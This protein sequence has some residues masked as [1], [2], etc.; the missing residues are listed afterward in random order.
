MAAK[1]KAIAPRT[2]AR[3]PG[4]EVGAADMARRVAQT[5]ATI[6]SRRE[7]SLDQLSHVTG[8][9]SGRALRIE[10]RKTNPTIGVLWKI[11]A[12]LGV[13]FSG[14]M[15]NRAFPSR[16]CG[17]QTHRSCAPRIASSRAG[18]SCPQPASTEIEMYELDLAARSRHASDPHGPGTKELVVVLSGSLRLTVGDHTDKLTA[19]DSGGVRREPPARLRESGK[20]GSAL[21]RRDHLPTLKA[22]RRR[23]V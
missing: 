23:P 19:G 21:S 4:D 11:A 13:P 2:A 1:K 14:L 8:V 6:A 22:N 16:S 20:R 3:P 5:C 9:S 12:G 10:T 18:R 7:L 15:G 17:G